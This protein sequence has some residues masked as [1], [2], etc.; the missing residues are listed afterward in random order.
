ME[1][2]DQELRE[3]IR[4]V[5]AEA[6][7]R[8]AAEPSPE[9]ILAYHE[10]RLDPADR[11]AV[12]EG[13]AAN[14]EAAR[15]LRDLARFP[16]VKADPGVFVPSD[17]EVEAGWRAFQKARGGPTASTS[18]DGRSGGRDERLPAPELAGP[19]E[20]LEPPRERR[21][22]GDH[23][24]SRRWITTRR[25]AVV[26][27]LAA[28]LLVAV[29]LGYRLGVQAGPPESRINLALAALSPIGGGV[30]RGG[31]VTEVRVRESAEGVLLSLSYMGA[32]YPSY[33]L[34]VYD[35]AGKRVLHR[36]DLE[37]AEAGSF[38]LDLP[39][40]ILGS[41]R[42]RFELSAPGEDGPLAVYVVDLT[43]G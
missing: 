28:M 31:A 35:P 17:E 24:S 33:A 1:R 10:G 13:I 22:G 39:R 11:V 12:E 23:G 38:L 42:Y 32:A 27:G 9:Q 37:S 34:D 18:G 19:S 14:P 4:A 26:V 5:Q 15:L 29:G 20:R 16:E 2:D 30:D 40:E 43:F 25:V 41:G 36:A 8:L 3:R 6:G 21:S 7:E